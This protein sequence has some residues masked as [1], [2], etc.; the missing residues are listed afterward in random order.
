MNWDAVGAIAELVGSLAVVITIVF[1][2][3]QLRYNST[4]VRNSTLQNQTT[5]MANW[6]LALIQDPELHALYRRG[7]IDQDG[8][9]KEELG[10]FD[11]IML[12]AFQTNTT[13]Y[14]Q[15]M[16]G[17]MDENIWID[18]LRLL[19][20]PLGTPGGWASWERQKTML[21]ENFQ[22]EIDLRMSN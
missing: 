15:Y 10:R 19:Q 8:L 9:A 4:A 21:P 22:K 14:Q 2:V 1:L 18:S 16:N 20:A 17:S 3:V 11:L 5:A 7:L 13:I 6:T 12:L